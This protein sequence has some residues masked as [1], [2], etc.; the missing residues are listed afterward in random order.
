MMILRMRYGIHPIKDEP[1]K[2]YLLSQKKKWMSLLERVPD[3]R[4]K[5]LEKEIEQI[6][7]EN[8]LMAISFIVFVLWEYHDGSNL[9]F[10]LP[11]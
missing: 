7:K 2:S 11:E 9:G 6:E 10:Q 3:Q 4:R 1:Y 8:S 5:E